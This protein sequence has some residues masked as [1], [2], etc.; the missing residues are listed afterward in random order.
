M[1]RNK[2]TYFV[3]VYLCR[4][5]HLVSSSCDKLPT[6]CYC[7]AETTVDCPLKE[8]IFSEIT[9]NF[10]DITAFQSTTALYEDTIYTPQALKIEYFKNFPSLQIIRI[11]KCSLTEISYEN[12]NE[13]LWNSLEFLSLNENL[14]GPSVD[15][16]SFPNLPKIKSLLLDSNKI[17][18]II[19]D[20]FSSSKFPELTVLS[21]KN[22]LIS[23]IDE[24][25]FELPKLKKLYLNNNNVKSIKHKLSLP[26][27]QMFNLA[28]N[29]VSFIPTTVFDAVKSLRFFDLREVPLLNWLEILTFLNTTAR[30]DNQN[31]LGVSCECIKSTSANQGWF[32]FGR[33]VSCNSQT[34]CSSCLKSDKSFLYYHG[35][36]LGELEK[37]RFCPTNRVEK[38]INIDSEKDIQE[39]FIQTGDKSNADDKSV[40]NY[41]VL[42]FTMFSHMSFNIL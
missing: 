30:I 10:D 15:S 9:E 25:S 38:G 24:N 29:E 23:Q 40:K 17:E 6:R 19:K 11:Q 8:S 36:H 4:F 12:S 2:I 33:K 18:H 3:L 42:L 37:E 20:T 13:N 31:T 27:L 21:I 16:L 41:H 32:G 34:K 14:I 39:N 5:F 22:N 26:K 1:L 28:N 7:P 35:K